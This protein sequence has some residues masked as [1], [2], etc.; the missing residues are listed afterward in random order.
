MKIQTFSI[1]VGTEA[2][3]ARCPF[4]VSQM[5]G[6]DDI[7]AVDLGSVGIN[8]RNLKKAVH[9]AK[10]GETTTLLLTG[11]GEPTLYPDSITE[12]CHRLGDQFPFIELQTN[13]IQLGLLGTK[14]EA[15][16][17]DLKQSTVDNWYRYGLN[18]IAIST[19]GVKPEQN[20]AIYHKNYPKLE[21][22]IHYLHEW[23]FSVRL[24]VMMMKG[25][26][27]NPESVMEV[28][29]FCRRHQVEQ[30]TLRPIRAPYRIESKAA[31]K[32]A[33]FVEEHIIPDISFDEFNRELLPSYPTKPEISMKKIHEWLQIKGTKL[34]SLMHG[35]EVYDVEEQNVCLS[36]CLTVDSRSDDIRTLIFYPN[37]HITYD[38]QYSG[39]N[40]LGPHRNPHEVIEVHF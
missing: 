26:V 22:T 34:L 2:C 7:R 14:G 23:G 29:E 33:Q 38:W 36:D 13:G 6:Y 25:Y 3:D 9:L 19:V 27:D 37:G 21:L 24:C 8:W 12:L 5:T 16:I 4:C 31:E 15:Q 1:V 17:P 10:L 28:V 39:A 40:L 18:T 20:S 30:L 32:A 35:A 11:K